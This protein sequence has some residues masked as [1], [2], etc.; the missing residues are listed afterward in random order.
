MKEH[1]NSHYIRKSRFDIVSRRPD[2]LYFLPECNGAANSIQPV[3]E[4]DFDDMRE[5]CHE[6]VEIK[7]FQEYF[8]HVRDTLHLS[9]SINWR[10][11]LDLY[12]YFY[13]IA[14]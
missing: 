9:P 6:N 2:E 14:Q 7:I 1:W 5:Y 3:D 11:A 13:Q 10:N 4:T 8:L 12:E